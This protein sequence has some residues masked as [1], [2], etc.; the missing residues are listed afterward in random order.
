MYMG[1][2]A[3][4]LGACRNQ[5]FIRPIENPAC[6]RFLWAGFP[7][8]ARQGRCAVRWPYF[9]SKTTNRKTLNIYPEI[10]P[11]VEWPRAVSRPSTGFDTLL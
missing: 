11:L 7:G 2:L 4:P 6:D 10:A 9:F 1:S 5:F 8:T 3:R